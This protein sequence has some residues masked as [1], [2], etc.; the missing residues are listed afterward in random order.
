METLSELGHVQFLH[1]PKCGSSFYN[2]VTRFACRDVPDD[3]VL[4]DLGGCPIWTEA[5]EKKWLDA[6]SFNCSPQLLHTTGHHPLASF[7]EARQAAAMFRQPRLRLMAGIRHQSGVPPNISELMRMNKTHL[8]PRDALTYAEVARLPGK[9]GCMTKMLTGLPC[10]QPVLDVTEYSEIARRFLELRRAGDL[11]GARAVLD[12]S[13]DRERPL[14]LSRVPQA[15]ATINRLLFV[16][17]TEQWDLSVALFHK[18]VAARSVKGASK[19]IPV[20]L[21][22]MRPGAY[23]SNASGSVGHVDYHL[24]VS[25][26]SLQRSVESAV[27]TPH[28]HD[29][30]SLEGVWDPADEQIFLAAE[31]RMS[32]EARALLAA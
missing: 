28:L 6:K 18:T 21:H 14:L 4:G 9:L 8:N 22:N 26:D 12:E 31:Q 5:G 1:F 7:S 24:N 30:S 11:S 17:M 16:G 15:L 23:S 29:A 25:L 32:T 2:T 10:A 27:P 19:I 13:V 20:E 3:C